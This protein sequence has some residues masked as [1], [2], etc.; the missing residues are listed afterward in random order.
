MANSELVRVMDYILNRCDEKTIDAVAAAVVRRRRE[1]AAFGGAA[2]LPDPRKMAAEI[3]GQINAGASIEGMRQTV[4]DMAVRI[5]K[6]EAPELTEKQIAE[7][8]AAWIPGSPGAEEKNLPPDLLLEMADQ[9]VNYSAGRM[10]E[11]EDK[12]LRSD[13]GAWPER[14]WKAFPQV[15]RLI[16]KDLLDGEITE[17]EYRSKLAAALSFNV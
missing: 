12:R 15:I 17:G 8:T 13:L 5:I 9:F 1:L 16:I 10:G 6:K 2:R 14:Y 4:R 7:L 11:T 3:S